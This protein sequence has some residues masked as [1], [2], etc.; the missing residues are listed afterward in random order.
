MPVSEER[1]LTIAQLQQRIKQV[2]TGEM[3]QG[4]C[5]TGQ[6][7][8]F[9]TGGRAGHWYFDLK[10]EEGNVLSCAM[11]A[12]FAIASRR[13]FAPSGYPKDGAQVI[14]RGYLSFYE[15]NGRLSFVAQ[16]ME[17]DGTGRLWMLFQETRARLQAEGLFDP[18]HKKPIPRF[19]RKIA[20]LTSHTGEVRHDVC[21]VACARNPMIPI[22]LV[23]IPVQGQNAPDGIV[24]GLQIAQAIPRV[25]VIIL[26]RGGGS[27]E[28][29]WCFNDER[30]ARAI[31]ESRIPV[32][33]GIG[34]EPDFTIAD[35]VADLRAST[36]SN[37]AELVVPDRNALMHQLTLL[38]HRMEGGW[39]MRL[40]AF[41]ERLQRTRARMAARSP[42]VSL[43]KCRSRSEMVRLRLLHAMQ[44][45]LDARQNR[46]IE[47]QRR[48][49][50]AVDSHMQAASQRV[51]RLRWR[52]TGAVPLDRVSAMLKQLEAARTRMCLLTEHRL[53]MEDARLKRYRERL[54]G[55]SPRHILQRGYVMVTDGERVITRRSQAP[56]EMQLQFA[57]GPLKV[58]KS[59]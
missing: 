34:H 20:L 43:Q 29:L 31:Y 47:D 14:V 28:D 4:L 16:Q 22:C 17:P 49:D 33:T 48:L 1:P 6:V 24:R 23:P 55:S 2:L 46:L 30:V 53:S 59:S 57:D 41:S 26:A 8:G 21:K 45:M 32:V 36:P 38:R 12:T 37:A 44:G 27:M 9:K 13:N 18:A 50:Q 19:P 52:M 7:S 58:R 10:D 51:L 3:F 5:V 25:D 15:K 40:K 35:D 11:W 39:D 56:E 42:L 54:Q